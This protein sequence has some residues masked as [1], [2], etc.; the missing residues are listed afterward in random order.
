MR[1]GAARSRPGRRR[2]AMAGVGVAALTVALLV[3]SCAADG[4]A[5]GDVQ[6]AGAGYQ[7]GDGSYTTWEPDDRPGP[8]DLTGESYGGETIDLD[9]WRG[10]VV[11]VNFWYAA[12][13]PC[14]AEAADLVAIH[15]DYAGSA[16]VLGINPRD[17]AGT[18]LA[19]E[20]TFEVPYPS[21]HDSQ[22][23]GVAAM[24]GQVPLQAMPTTVVLD[25]EG[26]IAARFLGQIDPTVVRGVMD[27]V[28]AESGTSESDAA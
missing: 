12:C 23:R 10:D 14:R 24:E 5:T 26:R 4:G 21:L 1:R 16:H 28:I 25:A 18:A 20:R 27:D 9:D 17:D 11:V 13:P 19:F 8:V 7:E 2:G 3:T 22:A 6:V 15:D